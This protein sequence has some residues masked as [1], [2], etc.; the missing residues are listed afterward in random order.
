MN[1]NVKIAIIVAVLVAIGVV[2]YFVYKNGKK[3]ETTSSSTST[4]TPNTVTKKD[5]NAS[6]YV[7]LGGDILKDVANSG[8]L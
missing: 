2:A 3:K 7:D 6:K 5:S 1:K 8:I 4:V